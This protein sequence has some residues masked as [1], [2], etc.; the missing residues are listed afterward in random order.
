MNSENQLM[1]GENLR[2]QNVIYRLLRFSANR[3]I[4]RR[5]D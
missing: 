4:Y 2:L 1:L 5:N 3:A